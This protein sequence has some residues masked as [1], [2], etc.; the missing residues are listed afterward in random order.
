MVLPPSVRGGLLFP[1]VHRTP[2]TR[3]KHRCLFPRTCTSR[4]HKVRFL[5]PHPDPQR[6]TWQIAMCDRAL[7]GS[8]LYGCR[9]YWSPGALSNRIAQRDWA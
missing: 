7:S 5:Y 9:G 2:L 8:C 1:V 6:E 3:G 4:V